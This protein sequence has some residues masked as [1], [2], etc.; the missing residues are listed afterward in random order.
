MHDTIIF[1]RG[2]P[3]AEAFPTAQIAECMA[4]A[5]ETDAAVVLQYGH[6]PGYAPL[7]ALLA[8][9]YG[10]KDNEIMVANGSL[11]VQ[12]LLAAHLVR[13]G[14]TVLTEQ[15]SYD[16]AITTFRRN[17]AVVTEIGRAHV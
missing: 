1:T 10:V 8:A 14:A 7:R 6:Q 3:P 5:I 11:Q 12:D 4:T 13:P 15:P 17:G 16:R 9:D 2:V